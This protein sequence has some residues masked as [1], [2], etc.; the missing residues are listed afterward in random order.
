MIKAMES[1]SDN[2][3]DMFSL[4]LSSV[5]DDQMH[6]LEN[7]LSSIINTSENDI[8]NLIWGRS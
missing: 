8:W 2:I 6:G 5:A 7:E 3:Y 1:A 4:S